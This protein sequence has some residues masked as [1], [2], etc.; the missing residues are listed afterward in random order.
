MS[1]LL[2]V[3]GGKMG[4]ALL[5]GLLRSGFLGPGDV[6]VIE[7]LEERRDE[8]GVEFPGVRTESAP[9]RFGVALTA[10]RTVTAAPCWR[11]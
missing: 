3:G 11:R 5:G 10:S 1:S 8:L 4:G 2:V 7:P 6:T 9:S